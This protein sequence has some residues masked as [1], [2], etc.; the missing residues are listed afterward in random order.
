MVTINDHWTFFEG[1]NFDSFSL[2]VA[3]S[4]N[5]TKKFLLK[6]ARKWSCQHWC[7]FFGQSYGLCGEKDH[8]IMGLI[9]YFRNNNEISAEFPSMEDD[10]NIHIKSGWIPDQCCDRIYSVYMK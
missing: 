1:F 6:H 3:F 9:E 2:H 5:A 10:Q 8:L 4:K 7:K